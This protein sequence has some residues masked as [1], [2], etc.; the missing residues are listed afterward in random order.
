VTSLSAPVGVREEDRLRADLYDFLAALLARPPDGEMIER[1]LALSGDESDLGMAI[2]ALQRVTASAS[3]ESIT[4]EYNRLFIGLGRG[5]LIPYASY[6]LTGFLNEKPLA[7]LREDM[8]A[9]GI[10]REVDVHEPED[11]IASLC[12]MMAGLIHGRFGQTATL[13]R[14]REF[15]YRHI[16]SWAPHF[17]ADLKGAK[18]SLFYAPV[19]AIGAIFMDIEKEA[20][21]MAGEGPA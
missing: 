20:F 4:K 12:E 9:L 17:F 15:F 13:S 19:G 2:G 1:C 5:E 21:R 11:N 6:Y 18:N 7:H 16:A 14:Q 8:A 3:Q 10:Q